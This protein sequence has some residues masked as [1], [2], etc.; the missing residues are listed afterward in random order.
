M[1]PII[2][3]ALTWSMGEPIR[4]GNAEWTVKYARLSSQEDRSLLTVTALVAHRAIGHD[5]IE[6][7]SADFSLVAGKAETWNARAFTA[8]I[9]DEKT[10][11]VEAI[12]D[13]TGRADLDGLLLKI[14]VTSSS[15][16]ST[17]RQVLLEIE[18]AAEATP[19]D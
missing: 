1:D 13:V 9:E 19:A 18:G 15:F 11:I 10:E 16:G 12:F 14:R 5:S 6:V 3:I 17:Y 4:A 8:M 7:V 2:L